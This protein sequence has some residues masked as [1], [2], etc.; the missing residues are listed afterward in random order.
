MPSLELHPAIGTL[1]YTLRG[2]YRDGETQAEKASRLRQEGFQI[3]TFDLTSPAGHPLFAVAA[4]HDVTPI[5]RAGIPQVHTADWEATRMAVEVFRRTVRAAPK[6]VRWYKGLDIEGLRR[7]IRSY[8]WTGTHRAVATGILSKTILAHPFPN[9]NH[10]TSLYLTRMFLLSLGLPWPSYELRGRGIRRFTHD[11]E[12]FFHRS[13][14]LLQLVRHRPL[15]RLAYDEGFTHLT[16]GPNDVA[17]SVADLG[18]DGTDIRARHRRLCE[19]LI[20]ELSDE[21][22]RFLLNRSNESSLGDW[23]RRVR[24]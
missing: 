14:F 19:N 11:T 5:P 22:G 7:C 4:R 18:L 13:K 12:S 8:D 2:L 15:I 6:G 17:I 16:I 23:I 21:S 1:R 24:R 20:V 10:R 3:A 9:A